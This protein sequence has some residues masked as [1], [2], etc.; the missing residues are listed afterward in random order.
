M[1]ATVTTTQ[2]LI[3]IA[4]PVGAS[5]LTFTFLRAS[6]SGAPLGVIVLCVVLVGLSWYSYL[7][8]PRVAVLR[9][10]VLRCERP[11]G[12]VLIPTSDI[13]EIDARRW[14]RGFACISAQGRRIFFLRAMPGLLEILSTIA[15]DR[16]GLV[17]QGDLS[18]RAR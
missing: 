13:R 11:M 15:T 8:I 16:G 12:R 17:V 4:I 2:R 6:A 3:L 5:L 1:R 14:N 10:G 18:S 7:S 9:D